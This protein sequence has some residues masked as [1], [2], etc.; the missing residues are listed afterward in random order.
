MYTYIARRQGSA[1]RS[2][3]RGGRPEDARGGLSWGAGILY[4]LFSEPLDAVF[5]E[6]GYTNSVF[7]LMVY[8]PGIVGVLLVWKH[9]GLPGLGRFFRRFA[10]VRMSSSAWSSPSGTR[11]RSC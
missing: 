10:L 5:G 3:R 4:V 1:S 6:M 7:I 11:R 2:A 8:S 9:D